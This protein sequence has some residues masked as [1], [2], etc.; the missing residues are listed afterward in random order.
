[1]NNLLR[2]RVTIGAPRWVVLVLWGATALSSA[3]LWAQDKSFEFVG[4]R[5]SVIFAE[6]RERTVLSGNARIVSKNTELQ[7]DHIEVYGEDFRFAECRGNV[8]VYDQEQGYR[9]KTEE[10]FFDRE[11]EIVR[12]EGLTVMEDFEHEIVI[13]GEYLEHRNLENRSEVQIGVRILGEDI[14]A[15]AEILRYERTVQTLE[16]TG[17]PFV[18]WQGNQYQG[19]RVIVDLDDETVELQGQVFGTIDIEDEPEPEEAE[20]EDADAALDATTD[21]TLDA[22]TP[23]RAIDVVPPSA[24]DITA[25]ATT[26][27]TLDIA[28]DATTDATLDATTPLRAIDVVPPSA[29]DITAD[30][31]TDATLDIA[32]DDPLD[33]TTETP[34]STIDVV[35]TRALDIGTADTTLDATTDTPLRAIDVVPPSALDTTADAIPTPAITIPPYILLYTRIDTTTDTALDATTDVVLDATTDTALDATTDTELDTTSDSIPQG[36]SSNE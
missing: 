13:K 21:A 10:L 34:L 35:P 17:L 36:S 22:T 27:A 8:I 28:T 33:A 23:L 14:N 4:D 32:T 19:N 15:R 6:G 31:T 12:S 1:M 25:D 16:L 2:A 29:L 7:A 3:P 9:L 30:A 24:L 5:T 18:I 26:D 11:L 20:Q